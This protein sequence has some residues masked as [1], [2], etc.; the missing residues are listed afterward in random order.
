MTHCKI[1]EKI[2]LHGIKNVLK[3]KFAQLLQILHGPIFFAD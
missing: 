1:L 3:V 2:I